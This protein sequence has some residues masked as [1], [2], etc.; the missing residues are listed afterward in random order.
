M[1]QKLVTDKLSICIP[2]SKMAE[3]PVERL[4]KLSEKKDRS[5]NYVVVEAILYYLDREEK[6]G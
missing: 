2:Q 3:K 4:T 1:A 6:K 5:V